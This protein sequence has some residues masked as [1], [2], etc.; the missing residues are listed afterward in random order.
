MNSS[1][2]VNK[3]I[4]CSTCNTRHHINQ[5]KR[6]SGCSVAQYCS[7]KC[8]K[9]DWPKHK[10]HCN[11]LKSY[12]AREYIEDASERRHWSDGVIKGEYPEETK[13]FLWLQENLQKNPTFMTPPGGNKED[14]QIDK[15][16]YNYA[17]AIFEGFIDVYDENPMKHYGRVRQIGWTIWDDQGLELRIAISLLPEPASTQQRMFLCQMVLL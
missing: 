17:R 12:V 9:S 5:L 13:I 1:S 11:D 8:Q 14:F 4:R 7:K 10:R 16:N 2:S 3:S 6:C 15:F